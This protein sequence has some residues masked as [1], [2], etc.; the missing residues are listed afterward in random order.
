MKR[1]AL[2]LLVG[3]A[4]PVAAQEVTPCDWKSSAQ[5]I[6]EP[7]GENS[8]TFANGDVRIALLD[9]VEPAAGAYYL[10]I[11][12]PP[13][14]EVGDRQC[15]VIGDTAGVGFASVD[16]DSLQSGYE[17]GYGLILELIARVHEPL[18]D[19]P[20][21]RFLTLIINQSSGEITATI[22]ADNL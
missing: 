21:R 3:L 22:S 9:T 20:P 10:L 2:S 19:Y 18:L 5:N 17:P 12:S 14:D 13:F 7:W 1:A 8:R 15:T 6:V 11:L 4:G 16:F